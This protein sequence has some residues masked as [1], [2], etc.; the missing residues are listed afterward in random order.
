MQ[1]TE[2]LKKEAVASLLEQT[3]IVETDTEEN[4]FE[5]M[6]GLSVERR[7]AE[8]EKKVI[9]HMGFTSMPKALFKIAGR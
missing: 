8:F 1:D 9:G 5:N 4:F 2:E 3:T 7:N 6:R